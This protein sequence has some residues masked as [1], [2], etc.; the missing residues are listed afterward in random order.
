MLQYSIFEKKIFSLLHLLQLPEVIKQ[1]TS[2]KEIIIN[3]RKRRMVFILLLSLFISYESLLSI[4]QNVIAESG[5]SFHLLFDSAFDL[6]FLVVFGT[7]AGFAIKRWFDKGFGLVI[8]REG[9]IDNSGIVPSGTI[10]WSEVEEIN[11]SKIIFSDCVQVKVRHP[12]KFILREGNL[13]NRIWLWL[14]NRRS[15]SP[16]NISGS[17]LQIKFKELFSIVQHQYLA[18]QVETRT[19]DLRR[20][21][22]EILEEKNELLN[23][24]NYAKR[25]QT[26]LLPSHALIE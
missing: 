13:F 9:I 5:I 7:V 24:I 14:E 16:V 25:I 2:P 23:S 20:E 21:K 4:Y 10:L 3:A 1:T 19:L 11:T 17:G 26:A 12:Q 22:D 6:A 15:G 8:N 18:S